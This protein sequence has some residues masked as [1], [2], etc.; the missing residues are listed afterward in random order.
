MYV[1]ELFW[2]WNIS[3]LHSGEY[4]GY[5][6]SSGG[7]TP[8]KSRDFKFVC[9][10][11]PRHF[12]CI[13]LKALHGRGFSP[14]KCINCVFQKVSHQHVYE[15]IW[16]GH[17]PCFPKV[18][19]EEGENGL[20]ALLMC[21]PR[22]HD[23]LE[24]S[25]TGASGG[26]W[27]EG[28]QVCGSEPFWASLFCSRETLR[29][30]A[31]AESPNLVWQGKETQTSFWGSRAFHWGSYVSQWLEVQNLEWKYHTSSTPQQLPSCSRSEPLEIQ[32]GKGHC[33]FFSPQGLLWARCWALCFISVT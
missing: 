17:F 28:Q 14:S 8:H 7:G 9:H 18:S 15:R 30:Q 1:K 31:I 26:E 3:I 20:Q 5:M 32:K 16:L 19:L 11:Q 22:C 12:R 13:L 4:K 23:W 6:T 33:Q 10:K 2:S 21:P 29:E 27:G 24:G 25:A